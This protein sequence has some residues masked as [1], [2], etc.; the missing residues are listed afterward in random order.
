MAF[1]I[2]VLRGK[3][4]KAV[5]DRSKPKTVRDILQQ[6]RDLDQELVAWRISVPQDWETF[7]S[8]SPGKSPKDAGSEHSPT[9][10]GFTASYPDLLIAKLLSHFRVHSIAIQALNIRC[11][12][13]INRYG[14]AEIP[15][16]EVQIRKDVDTAVDSM[17]NVRAQN[18]IRTLVDG[19]CASVPFHLDKLTSK[20]GRKESIG[21]AMG[22]KP[23]AGGVMLLQLLV[24]A[25]SAPGVPADQ[26][27][28][29]L[30]KTLEIAKYIG[31]DE[32]MV[33]KVLNGFASG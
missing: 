28:W 23:P 7:S 22:P 24:V 31:M 20:G 10:R 2:A 11:V 16:P 26:K 18:V 6:S 21:V 5:L 25:Y 32:G 29:I 19:I 12:N 13:W 27:R 4:D 33:E 8:I 30:G 3:L 15:T 17:T 14:C 9:W 1:A